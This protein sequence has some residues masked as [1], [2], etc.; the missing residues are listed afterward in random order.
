M[1]HTPYAERITVN[2][3][4]LAG[5]PVVK[6]T[7]VSVE[8]VLEQLASNLDVEDVLAAFPHLTREDIGAC[9]R[10]A[11]AVVAGEDIHP[12]ESTAQVAPA[13]A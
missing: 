12:V 6:G 11:R 4:V 7:R 13:E 1:L 5:K 10:Y 8:R 2:P 3:R 9:V